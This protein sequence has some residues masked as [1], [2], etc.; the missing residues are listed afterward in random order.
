MPHHHRHPHPGQLDPLGRATK[1]SWS[2]TILPPGR[3]GLPTDGQVEGGKAAVKD[4]LVWWR[5][6]TGQRDNLD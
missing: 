1:A 6:H 4:R 2:S 3:E 5:E